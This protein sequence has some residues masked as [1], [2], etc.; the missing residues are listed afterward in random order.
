MQEARVQQQNGKGKGHPA[1]K[2]G[3]IILK[4]HSIYLLTVL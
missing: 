1:D 3:F 2:L 4:N